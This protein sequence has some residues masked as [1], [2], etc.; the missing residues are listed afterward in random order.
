MYTRITETNTP[1]N[2]FNLK[3]IQYKYVCIFHSHSFI[4]TIRLT[5]NVANATEHL[6]ELQYSSE[7]VYVILIS[8]S[9]M[10]EKQKN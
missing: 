5:C 10:I 3:G 2:G 9:D 7:W 8:L 4:T 6:N 1:S